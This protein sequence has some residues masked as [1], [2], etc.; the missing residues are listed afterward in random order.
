[1]D[2]YIH[3]RDNAQNAFSVKYRASIDP[4]ANKWELCAEVLS[5]KNI[6]DVLSELWS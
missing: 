6:V 1:M 5:R 2:F 4:E 3:E